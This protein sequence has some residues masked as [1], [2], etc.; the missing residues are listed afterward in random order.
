MA[1][2]DKFVSLAE[3]A[4]QVGASRGTVRKW[5]EEDGVAAVVLGGGTLRYRAKDVEA[6][7]EECTEEGDDEGEEGEDDDETEDDEAGSEDADDEDDGDEELEEEDDDGF[8]S[9]A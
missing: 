3:V 4:E 9:A 8:A 5:L 7:L 1:K 2:I 6:W